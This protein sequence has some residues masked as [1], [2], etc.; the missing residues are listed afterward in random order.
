MESEHDR[1]TRLYAELGDEHLEDLKDDADDLTEE[2]RFALFAELRKRGMLPEPIRDEA[3]ITPA[4]ER[5]E[6]FGPTIPGFMPGGAAAVEH[7]LEPGGEERLGWTSLTTFYDGHEL[8][9]ACEAL[10]DSEVEF[11][12]EARDGDAQSSVPPRF[13]IWAKAPDIDLA[14]RVLREKLGLFPLAEVE[15]NGADEE[16]GELPLAHFD[17]QNEA[18]EAAS[19]LGHAGIGYEVE[20]DEAEGGFWIFVASADQPRALQ[21]VADSIGM[22]PTQ[23]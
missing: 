8:T 3:A 16:D 21:I 19:L 7:A 2:G 12:I 1:L 10:E 13:D 18:D 9:R 17:T 20:P 22:T 11:A 14:Q 23:P 4:G 6:G 15:E 5:E